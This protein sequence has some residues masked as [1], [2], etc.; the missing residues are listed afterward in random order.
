[1]IPEAAQNSIKQ[2]FRRYVNGVYSA[3]GRPHHTTLISLE[4]VTWESLGASEERARL[5]TLSLH[6]NG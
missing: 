1:M 5:R 6:A 3:D 4:T 2:T